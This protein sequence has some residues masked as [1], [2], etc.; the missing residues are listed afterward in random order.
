MSLVHLIIVKFPL[1]RDKLLLK[2][3]VNNDTLGYKQRFYRH[4]NVLPDNSVFSHYELFPVM[5][6]FPYFDEHTSEALQSFLIEQALLEEG[7]S[8]VYLQKAGDGNMNA[9]LRL[10]SSLG[11]DWVVKQ[12][13]PF[14]KK[15]PDFEAPEERI[16]DEVAF[17]ERFGDAKMPK[18]LAFLEEARLAV[19]EYVPEVS[20]GTF[21]YE[22][23]ADGLD[24]D[25]LASLKALA[26]WL[27]QLHSRTDLAL[28]L[29][30]ARAMAEFQRHQMFDVP[31]SMLETRIQSGKASP[32][33]QRA[34]DVCRSSAFLTARQGLNTR[35]MRESPALLHGDF[36]AKNWLFN[37]TGGFYVI[38]PEF[39]FYGPPEY[40]LGVMLAHMQLAQLPIPQMAEVLRAY[41]AAA[42]T[43]D[44]HLCDGFARFERLRRLL[45]VARLPIEPTKAEKMLAEILDF[46]A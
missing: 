19:Y 38:D 1:F 8:I 22:G 28:D 18:L 23:F 35:L 4:F 7:E 10:K 17:Y 20:D 6:S 43:Y 3:S 16:A 2:Y 39:C 41:S 37:K 30:A 27:G 12:S 29:P 13:R 46:Y 42:G 24:A 26:A 34:W 45:G 5:S 25:R 40:D 14:V 11:K 44:A 32:W 31:F 9:T 36:F 33:E 15:Y 21:L